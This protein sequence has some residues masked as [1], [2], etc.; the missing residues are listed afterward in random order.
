MTL[1]QD[2]SEEEQGL[3]DRE[4]E[5]DNRVKVINGYYIFTERIMQAMTFY[6]ECI[7]YAFNKLLQMQHLWSTSGIPFS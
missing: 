6:I 3:A 4:K 1:E 7:S 5:K 2:Y